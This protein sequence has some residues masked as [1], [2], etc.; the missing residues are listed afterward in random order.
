MRLL[1]AEDEK[2]LSH[3]LVTI[4]EKSHYSVDAVYD[5]Q[6]ALEYLESEAYDG[7]ILDIMMPKVDGITVLKTIRKQGNK[8]PVLILS[9]KSEIEDKVDG[10]DAGANDYLAK[11]FDARELL[12]RIRVITRVNTESNDSLIRFGH[13]TLNRKTY[14]LKGEKAEFKLA[15]K[16]FQMM[17]LLMDNPHQVLSTDRIFEKIWGY[18]SDTEIN[19]VWVYIAYLRKKLVKMHADIEIK[20][21]RN[22]GYSV[23]LKEND[24]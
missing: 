22:V 17:E 20:A 8:I 9:A 4:L 12:A 1:L 5:G 13:V 10:L 24:S 7:L 23:E 3:A 21:H 19:I 14:V 18:E 6:E 15:N 2:S 11:P 16:E